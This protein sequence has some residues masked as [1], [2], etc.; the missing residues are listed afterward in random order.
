[1]TNIARS[2]SGRLT[3]KIQCQLI[4]SVRKPPNSGPM[5]E[6]QP[7]HRPEQP[8]YCRARR[9]LNRSPMTRERDREERAG[10]EALDAAEQDQLVDVLQKPDRSDPEEEADADHQHWLAAVEGPRASKRD[11]DRRRD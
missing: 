2:P 6:A 11:R 9:G 3:K 8:W 4:V 1:M 10:A 7:E 5:I